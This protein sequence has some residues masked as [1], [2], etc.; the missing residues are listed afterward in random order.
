MREKTVY[1]H[2]GYHKTGTTSIQN[3]LSKNA[4]SLENLGFFYYQDADYSQKWFKNHTLALSIRKIKHP[5]IP[6]DEKP[7]IVWG[8]FVEAAD[9]SK[10]ATI[11]V[12]SEVFMEGVDKA[13]I[14]NCLRK[15]QVNIIFYVREQSDWIDSL[16]TEEVKHGYK[17]LVHE[18]FED[19]KNKKFNYYDEIESWADIFGK[20]R[21]I[22]RDYNEVIKS[23]GL[24]NDFMALIGL[25]VNDTKA[26]EITS[27]RSNVR[28]PADLVNILVKFNNLPL[29]L[30]EKIKLREHFIYLINKYPEVSRMEK[31][32]VSES[33]KSEIRDYCLSF[34]KS[35]SDNYGNGKAF[36]SK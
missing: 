21:I 15:F 18:Y 2:V 5:L 10:A 20:E 27:D 36:F 29:P 11:I 4:S 26:I 35:L 23:H 17:K 7:E 33:L 12:S 6:L 13:Y 8:R 3:T 22:V 32:K 31:F 34:N 9:R 14:K 19:T 24:L 28:F 30:S 16:Y 25:D 1:L